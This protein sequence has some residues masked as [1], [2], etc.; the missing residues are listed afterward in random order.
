MARMRPRLE[1]GSRARRQRKRRK[2]QAP[3]KHLG[4]EQGRLL[5]LQSH[6][7]PQQ[8]PVTT[9]HEL[10][11]LPSL[12][13]LHYHPLPP[14]LPQPNVHGQQRSI[15][16]K[17]WATPSAIVHELHRHSRR[18]QARRQPDEHRPAVGTNRRTGEAP[19]LTFLQP[20]RLLPF[21][22]LRPRL[23]ICR[24]LQMRLRE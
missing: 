9:L 7:P 19:P 14:L 5:L 3:Q 24:H 12:H 17:T 18:R 10:H 20:A 1:G 22:R 8:L 11:P 2:R 4:F 6:L 21:L 13:L 16:R 15:L 23:R